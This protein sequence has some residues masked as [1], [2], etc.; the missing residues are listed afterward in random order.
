MDA[1]G[2]LT[3]GKSSAISGLLSTGMRAPEQS[4]A[5]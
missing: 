5:I 4:Q 3:V 2:V 1:I